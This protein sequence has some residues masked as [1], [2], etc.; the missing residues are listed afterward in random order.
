MRGPSPDEHE[1]Y[2]PVIYV[3]YHSLWVSITGFYNNRYTY[4]LKKDTHRSVGI[5]F[6]NEALSRYLQLQGTYGIWM[7]IGT[8]T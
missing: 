3:I 2:L 5:M 6:R 8:M 1:I 7:Y 4:G